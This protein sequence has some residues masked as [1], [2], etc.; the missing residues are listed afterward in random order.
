MERQEA[1]PRTGETA[2]SF[3]AHLIPVPV[4]GIPSIPPE[5]RNSG[6]VPVRVT[7]IPPERPTLAENGI[8]INFDK[9]PKGGCKPASKKQPAPK[10]SD[11][12]MYS[13]DS[14]L[15]SCDDEE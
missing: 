13:D 8:K 5:R 9:C 11:D 1:S 10:K 3:P 14:D 4:T 12:D 15:E 6:S 2:R 7:G